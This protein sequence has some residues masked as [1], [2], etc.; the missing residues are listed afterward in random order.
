MFTP[1]RCLLTYAYPARDR[2]P[3]VYSFEHLAGWTVTEIQQRKLFMGHFGVLM[4]DLLPPPVAGVTILRDPVERTLSHMKYNQ[5]GL[6]AKVLP[7]E[8]VERFAP[9]LRG[10]WHGYLDSPVARGLNNFLTRQL[11]VHFDLR[12][13]LTG[14]ENWSSTALSEAVL[15]ARLEA[16]LDA[17]YLNASQL[18]SDL[19]IVGVVERFED[20]L[21]LVCDL[22]SIAPQQALT[23]NQSVDRRHNEAYTHRK[24]FAPDI[25]ERIEAMTVYDMKL[26][27]QAQQI[28]EEKLIYRQV[29]PPQK[30]NHART[31]N[32][33][34]C[35]RVQAPIKEKINKV[36]RQLVAKRPALLYNK[37]LRRWFGKFF[38]MN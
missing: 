24:S 21:L 3:D 17:A 32:V 9:L 13:Y 14:G 33:A 7:P 31:L 22:L 8:D 15:Q 4:Y 37:S 25:V 18:L 36:G 1:K 19:S 5:T 16:N 34:L 10:D 12:P 30:I 27:Q 23:L 28:L 2:F 20:T 38:R 11:G 6:K 35:N 29:H 26:Y